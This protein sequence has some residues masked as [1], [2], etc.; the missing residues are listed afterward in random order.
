MYYHLINNF[1]EN[2]FLKKSLLASFII[3]TSLLLI[4]E[5]KHF[6]TLDAYDNDEYGAAFLNYWR[7]GWYKGC[8]EGYGI[9]YNEFIGFF[10]RFTSNIYN[11]FFAANLISQVL[12]AI[13]SLKLLS[14]YKHKISS[15]EYYTILVLSI[16]QL[17]NTKGYDA[18]YD[19]SF[20]S[21]FIALITYILFTRINTI[22]TER[23]S[24]IWLGI[25]LAIC[26]SIRPT[27]A[28][29]FFSLTI[30][31]M[32]LMLK[33][34]LNIKKTVLNFSFLII[35][36]VVLTGVLHFPSLK[37]KGKLS[38][39]DKNSKVG[40]NWNQRNY[41]ALKQ[42]QSGKAPKKKD[43]FWDKKRW[44]EVDELLLKN[45]KNSIPNNIFKTF[46][47]DPIIVSIIT[48][49]NILFTLFWNIRNYG[50]L[51]LLPFIAM[52]KRPIFDYNKLPFLMFM[53]VCFIVSFVSL[54]FMEIRWFSG[55]L[56]LVPIGIILAISEIKNLNILK[57]WNIIFLFS[58]SLSLVM[59]LKTLLGLIQQ[60]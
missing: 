7:L 29:L 13:I 60:L 36:F 37:E 38:F 39:Y 53:L 57:Y 48:I 3:V 30:I 22:L 33:E 11:S 24:L 4:I 15:F 56:I 16:F 34:Q 32:I 31:F 51:I 9:L 1:L 18:S 41:H 19:D 12:C 6:I 23:K 49:Y 17:L 54:T 42:I 46:T 55:Y 25:L 59:N 20:L 40:A 58:I 27:T 43:V 52:F 47:S 21:V 14:K 44:E 2:K 26:L 10:Y 5:N 45:G 35:P 8:V 50:I 28:F